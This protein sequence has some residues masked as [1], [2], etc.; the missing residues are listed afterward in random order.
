MSILLLLL[1]FGSVGSCPPG[2]PKLE[3]PPGEYVAQPLNT[4]HYTASFV[5]YGE[6]WELRR[7]RSQIND[8]IV[9]DW[10]E[11]IKNEIFW[12]PDY[13]RATGLWAAWRDLWGRS[14]TI[15]SHYMNDYLRGI[16]IHYLQPAIKEEAWYW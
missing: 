16:R 3:A 4:P 6:P 8:Q 7:L 2:G 11:L 15:P 13:F 10:R 5:I 9:P 12:S 14:M 1:A